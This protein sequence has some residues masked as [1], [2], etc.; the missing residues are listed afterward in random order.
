MQNVTVALPI[1][2][3]STLH[4]FILYFTHVGLLQMF[5]FVSINVAMG[6][7]RV[8]LSIEVASCIR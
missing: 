5:L 6:K 8:G 4:T 1:G 3:L 7:H 2:F